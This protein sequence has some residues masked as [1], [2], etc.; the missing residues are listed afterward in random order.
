VALFLVGGPARA[1][2]GALVAVV[3]SVAAYVPF[4][5]AAGPHALWEHLAGITLRE[6]SAWRLPFP[7]LYDG[8]LRTWPPGD[9][10]HDGK[11]VIG[12]ELPIVALAGLVLG[13]AAV[14]VP[15]RRRRRARPTRPAGGT[16]SVLL[17]A[18]RPRH[19]GRGAATPA[20]PVGLAILGAFGAL[21]LRSRA[22]EFHVQPLAVCAA[23]L[24]AIA[25]GRAP[26]RAVAVL[27]ALPL[28]FVA[29]AGVA[30]RLS[31]LVL[32]PHLV[33][34]HVPGVPGI[35]VP[36][37]EATALPRVVAGV[38]RLVPPGTPVYV[39]PRRSDL[40]AFTDP[41]LYVL[42]RRPSILPDDASLQARPAEQA[43]IVAALRR[44]RPVVI[45][46]TDPL[47]T[48]R[49]PNARGRSSGVRTL[50]AYLARTYR[51]QARHGRYTIL[52]P[53]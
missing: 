45:R 21:Y 30:N 34:L 19:E 3:L 20:V 37:G 14:V 8:R 18:P 48:R 41:L 12:Y 44:R 42:V 40:V 53:G 28:A 32:P 9:L 26:R 46:W 2:R 23:A 36:P 22:D 29:L 24:L 17:A 47:S 13:A 38:D 31:A 43:R 50:D 39:A 6:G 51:V 33:A 16:A 52:V 1:A 27:L 7:V 5:V 25:A 35:G 4:L 11:D 15:A 10:L 49:E